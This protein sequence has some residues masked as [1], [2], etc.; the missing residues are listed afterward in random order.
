MAT[1]HEIADQLAQRMR[2]HA[3]CDYHP[4][5]DADPDNC[6]QCKDR[7]AYRTWEAKGGR[8]Y[9]PSPYDGPVLDVFEHL[10]GGQ[11]AARD[12]DTTTEENRT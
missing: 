4:E 2:H 5:R 10:H 3:Y 8:T 12:A 7:A 6:A 11:A 1:W 9:T